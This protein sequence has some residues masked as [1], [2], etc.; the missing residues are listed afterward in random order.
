MDKARPKRMVESRQ[1]LRYQEEPKRVRKM[2]RILK[3]I[4]KIK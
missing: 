4:S 1:M 2:L 3:E